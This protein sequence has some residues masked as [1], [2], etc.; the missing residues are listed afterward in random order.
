VLRGYV[1]PQICRT[2]DGLELMSPDGSVNLVPYSQ[3][4]CVSFVRDL[5]GASA[6]G[7]R[8]EF[9]ARPKAPGLW[10]EL[11]FRDHDSLEAIIPNNMLEMEPYGLAATPPE[12]AGNAQ[13]IFVPRAS[14]GAIQ[15]LGVIGK[16]KTR[17]ERS[18][19][20]PSRQFALF[21]ETDNL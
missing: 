8:R 6:L 1:Q 4:K 7:E 2:G 19:P 15:V 10:V 13:R 9:L 17:R 3:I 11:Q 5:E 21:S 16:P 18:V 20:A 12:T 14:L